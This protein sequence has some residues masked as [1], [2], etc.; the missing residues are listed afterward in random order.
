MT[1]DLRN[2]NAEEGIWLR[3]TLFD[4]HTA[5]SSEFLAKTAVP[6][7][8]TATD[9]EGFVLEHSLAW[10]EHEIGIRHVGEPYLLPLPN[11]NI[12]M[13]THTN[14]D[15]RVAGTL[16]D[17]Q[18]ESSLNSS[19]QDNSQQI[20]NYGYD[21]T[22]DGYNLEDLDFLPQLSDVCVADPQYGPRVFANETKHPSR[23]LVG[24][25]VDQHHLIANLHKTVIQASLVS[26]KG[27]SR[28]RRLKH[29]R[30]E[31]NQI[32]PIF[33]RLYIDEDRSLSD[34][35]K[36]LSQRHK[37]T[38]SE[39]MFK[40]RI[41]IWGLYK[42][43]KAQKE[44]IEFYNVEKG[45]AVDHMPAVGVPKSNKLVSTDVHGILTPPS[46][47]KLSKLLDTSPRKTCRCTTN[48]TE[49]QSPIL[50]LDTER[51]PI[52]LSPLKISHKTLGHKPAA[53]D[54]GENFSPPRSADLFEITEDVFRQEM[55]RKL[56]KQVSNSIAPVVSPS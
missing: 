8:Q 54:L 1:E 50:A 10:L 41:A 26:P 37:F 27:P 9:F 35:V 23:D 17:S 28:A 30:Q 7:S 15:S 38:A 56:C 49:E 32:Q 52:K 12:D 3:D 5:L 2:H 6:N 19:D 43:N 40:K 42:Y 4:G 29:S 21:L 16:T 13:N 44:V 18:P 39:Q 36:I 47:P 31:W 14:T 22:W 24:L 34:V 25:K 20:S 53:Q 33:K 46:S 48:H 11:S 55:A 45:L 51:P